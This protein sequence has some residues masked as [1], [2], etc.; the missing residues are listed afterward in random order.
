MSAGIDN[1]K[2][3][4]V[5]VAVGTTTTAADTY[6]SIGS[7]IQE[8]F[9]GHSI[10]WSY[11]SRKI[12]KSLD[13][14]GDR[15]VFSPVE[16][17][18]KLVSEGHRQAV[19]QPLYFLA[20][21]EFHRLKQEAGSIDIDIGFGRPILGS[22]LDYRETSAGLG[23]LLQTR[24]EDEALVLVGHGTSHPSW[25]GFLALEYFLRQRFDNRI[26]LGCIEH[27]PS[28]EETVARIIKGGWEKVCLIPFLL[29]AGY[30]YQKQL[31]GDNLNSWKSF[32]SA[33]S[34]SVTAIDK[35]MGMEPFIADILIRHIQEALGNL[36]DPQNDK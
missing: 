24:P 3:P 27:F 8:H 7:E 31:M 36:N 14:L 35:G 32:C 11:S 17:L 34:I 33:A 18:E 19:V 9:P 10:L 4:I 1:V 28:V 5:M 29:V 23:R 16:I 30:H 12:K 15:A 6:N 22:P 13:R 20:G 25:S 26:F 21:Y 2:I